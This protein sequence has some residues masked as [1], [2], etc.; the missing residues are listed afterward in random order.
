[1]SDTT[2]DDD[3]VSQDDID[4]LLESGQDEGPDGADKEEEFGELSQDDIDGLLNGSAMGSTSSDDDSDDMGDDDFELVSQDDIESLLKNASSSDM[5][6]SSDGAD[7]SESESM[8]DAEEA[9]ELVSQDDIDSL[10]E[11]SS[12]SDLEDS[13]DG[14][15]FSESENMEDAE[16]AE[17]LISQDDID[18]LL[19]D[20]SSSD[21]E[22]SS[23]GRDLSDSENGNKEPE[24]GSEDVID[25]SQ[26]IDI[27]DC[28]ITQEVL[29]QL[30]KED[31]EAENQ[32]DDE[33]EPPQEPKALSEQDQQPD[34]KEE[35]DSQVDSQEQPD[36]Q[37]ASEEDPDDAADLVSLEKQGEDVSQKDID[38]L[39]DDPDDELVDDEE[40]GTSLISQKDI[41]SLLGSSEE[42]DEDFLGDLDSDVSLENEDQENE[43]QEDDDQEDDD[44]EDDDYEEEDDED[45]NELYPG[46]EAEESNQVVLETQ[47]DSQLKEDR[48]A[49]EEEKKFAEKRV[50]LKKVLI[51]ASICV[52]LLVSGMSYY[53]VNTLKDRIGPE[54]Q[55]VVEEPV[56]VNVPE[57]ETVEIN[58]QKTAGLPDPGTVDLKG[59][60]VFSSSED[61]GFVYVS[62][63]LSID[64][65]RGEALVEINKH[66]ALYRDIIYDAI[67]HAISRDS[68]AVSEKE[69]LS[70]V[71]N[72]LNSA[73]PE[74]YI[75]KVSFTRFKTG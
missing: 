32:A 69:L 6:T 4:K 30:I 74:N 31:K 11:D 29:D 9:E 59:F 49:R 61:D 75:E 56:Q 15:D 45:D 10:L 38:S 13:S 63:D 66:M 3:L 58:L 54:N 44:Q 50:S 22:D 65:S 16:E 5:E 71:K 72:A 47:E 70:A 55:A 68:N 18:S 57:V 51:F 39:L 37:P 28:L 34:L 67:N 64:Y 1:M 40:D 73:L 46:D 21:L 20:S 2:T 42:E 33:I 19:E 36:P 26:G 7:L 27:Q 17:E 24:S 53:I 48:N 12:S 23:E 62:A 41:D 43:D 14:A 60:F 35:P 52:V 25:E 8:E